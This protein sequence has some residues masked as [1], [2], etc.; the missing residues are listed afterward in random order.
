[1]TTKASRDTAG[2]V[3][4]QRL[5]RAILLWA[6]IVLSAASVCAALDVERHSGAMA[7]AICLLAINLPGLGLI[8]VREFIG[9]NAQGHEPLG[10][11][12]NNDNQGPRNR[13]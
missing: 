7:A 9:P 6:A 13:S 1:M 2:G 4:L 10:A 8:V 3:G 5:V 12:K 11:E